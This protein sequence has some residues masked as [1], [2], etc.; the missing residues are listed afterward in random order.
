VATE[1]G[2]LRCYGEALRDAV[3]RGANHD[4]AKEAGRRACYNLGRQHGAA[5]PGTPVAPAGGVVERVGKAMERH[6]VMGDIEG[7]WDA[8]ARAAI[9][10]VADC[11]GGRGAYNVTQFLREEADHG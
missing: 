1:D 5:Q 2:L 3:K 6:H 8:Q 7:L 10:E 9:R 4:E 11:L